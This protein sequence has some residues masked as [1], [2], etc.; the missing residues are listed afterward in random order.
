MVQVAYIYV[1]EEKCMH[2]CGRKTG[3]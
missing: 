1:K 3:R 2:S